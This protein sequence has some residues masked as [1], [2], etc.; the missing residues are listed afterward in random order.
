[1]ELHPGLCRRDQVFGLQEACALQKRMETALRRASDKHRGEGRTLLAFVA[2][3]P[4]V[5]PL[6]SD[7]T[8][9]SRGSCGLQLVFL[10]KCNLRS[11]RGMVTEVKLAA[12]FPEA[13]MPFTARLAYTDQ[14]DL[15]DIPTH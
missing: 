7:P 10:N 1:M 11:M 6:D 15:S 4:E 2:R 9:L 14:G 13:R 12:G 8:T 3:L 5:V